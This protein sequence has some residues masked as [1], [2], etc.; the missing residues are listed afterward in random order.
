MHTVC[1]TYPCINNQISFN[2]QRSH[3]ITKMKNNINT[4]SNS[5]KNSMI[6][7]WLSVRFASHWH[8]WLE[9]KWSVKTRM[10]LQLLWIASTMLSR[11]ETP[12][13]KF[14]SVSIKL[15]FTKFYFKYTSNAVPSHIKPNLLDLWSPN[16]YW[17]SYLQYNQK[18]RKL[19]TWKLLWNT[20]LT[21][22]FC[23]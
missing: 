18:N 7:I 14:L 21:Y 12:G 9:T 19:N 8:H 6:N 11:T 4:D 2:S 5:F 1:C 3:T 16:R 20:I 10:T 23:T 17:S 22:L 13:V 15:C